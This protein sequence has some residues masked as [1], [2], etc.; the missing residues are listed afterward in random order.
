[1]VTV[2]GKNDD[3]AKGMTVSAL[4]EARGY[5]AHRV[6]VERNRCIVPKASYDMLYIEDGDILEI[7]G[8][9]GGG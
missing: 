3:S 5:D 9:V 7:V 4:L 6:A 2:N 1:M 8:F